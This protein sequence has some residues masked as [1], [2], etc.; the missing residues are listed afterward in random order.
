M[1]LA[2]APLLWVPA[3][4][5]K[6][7]QLALSQRLAAGGA[8]VVLTL[9]ASV[10]H[11]LPLGVSDHPNAVAGGA[12][13]LG[14]AA[15]HLALALMQGQAPWLNSWRRWSYAGF[16]VDEF[17]TRLVLRAWPA[18]WGASSRHAPW[19][20]KAVPMAGGR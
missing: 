14:M 15:M 20:A 17:F 4:Q 9:L 2:W 1:A 5:D 10:A 7:L 12:A 18:S 3:M 8:V 19:T 6:S 13:L 16:Y 11:L